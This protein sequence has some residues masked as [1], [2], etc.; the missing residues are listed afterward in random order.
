MSEII[1]VLEL[2]DGTESPHIAYVGD[3]DTAIELARKWNTLLNIET[4]EYI[5]EWGAR[6][7]PYS[8]HLY[9]YVTAII[10]YPVLGDTGNFDEMYADK[11]S[12]L[13]YLAKSKT[14]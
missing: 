8:V 6:W 1:Y 14:G 2:G 3:K 12:F 9:P 11:Q 5:E 4:T 13:A 10:H 7:N